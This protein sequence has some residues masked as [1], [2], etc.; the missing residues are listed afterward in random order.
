MLQAALRQLHRHYHP[1]VRTSRTRH[2]WGA[3][4]YRPELR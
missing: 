2:A 4:G 1:P 3:E